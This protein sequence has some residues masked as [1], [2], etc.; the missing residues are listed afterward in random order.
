MTTQHYAMLQ[1]KPSAAAMV[2]AAGIDPAPGTSN[3]R[4]VLVGKVQMRPTTRAG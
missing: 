3:V 4:M 1:R 2:E